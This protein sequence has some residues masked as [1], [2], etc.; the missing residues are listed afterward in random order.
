MTGPAG[1]PGLPGA[2]PALV[3]AVTPP[4]SPHR[5]SPVADGLLRVTGGGLGVLGGFLTGLLVVLLVPLRVRD[6]LWVSELP[7][8]VT[9]LRIPVA[10]VVAAGAAVF[11]VWFSRRATGV[12]WA[13]LLPAVGW[14]VMVVAALRITPEGARLLMPDD[15]V[16]AL[17]LFAGT[18]VLVVGLVLSLTSRGRLRR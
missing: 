4:E 2:D 6:L 9:A 18:L 14:L 17:A 10:V 3:P 16:A 13:P 1:G 12:R 11:L 7:G 8:G 5:P 15:W